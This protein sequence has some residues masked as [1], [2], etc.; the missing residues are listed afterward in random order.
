[1]EKPK[2]S[3]V[4]LKQKGVQVRVGI[5]ATGHSSWSERLVAELGFELWV[6]DAAENNNRQRPDWRDRQ[7]ILANC[8]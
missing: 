2:G 3:T 1:M 8:L 4:E 6:G 5:E 7:A